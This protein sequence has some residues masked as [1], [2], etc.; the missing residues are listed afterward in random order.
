MYGVTYFSSVV[1]ELPTDIHR[2]VRVLRERV[3]KCRSR[4]SDA[5]SE[6]Q[7]CRLCR[8]AGGSDGGCWE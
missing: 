7:W 4:E 3:R 6:R 2:K 5:E 8:E 1:R